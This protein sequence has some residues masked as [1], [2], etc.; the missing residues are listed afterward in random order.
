MTHTDDRRQD[1]RGS[2]EH[3][4]RAAEHLARRVARDAR[5][6]AARVEEHVGEFAGD[7]RRE[8]RCGAAA[9]GPRRSDSPGD[10]RRVFDD[11][12]GVLASVLEGVDELISDVFS[13]G[14]EET[15]TRVVC[16]RDTACEGCG[17]T[18]PTGGEGYVRRKA[19]GRQ[20]RC[21]ACGIPADGP[22]AT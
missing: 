22:H 7:V 15:W 19:G 3:L 16:N 11:I 18:V 2:W 13:G 20:F 4:G 1:A 5:Q 9:A 12:R 8:W 14:A 17:R 10:I 21:V 6:F